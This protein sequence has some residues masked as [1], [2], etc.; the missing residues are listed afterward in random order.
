MR[1]ASEEAVAGRAGGPTER[2][3]ED[4][5]GHGGTQRP[6]AR[7]GEHRSPAIPYVDI[8]GQ[9]RG[10]KAELLAA[11]GDVLDEAQ[12]VLG[13][14]VR[15]FEARFAELCGVRH[16]VAVNSGTD[17]LILSL[18]AL[19]IGPG[20]EVITPPNSFISSASCIVL[21]GARPVF[22]DV[23]DDFNLDPA[24]V[25][26]AITPRTKAILPVHLNGRP[27]QMG[28]IMDLAAAHGLAVV[29]DA[30]EAVLARYR[31]QPVGSFGIG[32]FSL[33]PLKTLNACGDGGVLTTDDERLAEQFR[34]LRNLGLRNRDACVLWSSNS[35]LDTIQAAILLVKLKYLEAWTL[36]R[37]EHAACYREALAGVPGVRAP[38]DRPEEWAVYHRFVIQAERRD[39]LKQFLAERGVETAVH[40]PIP[41][42]LQPAARDLGY[43]PG[44]FPMTERQAA[45]IL[46]LPVYPELSPQ[47]REEVVRAIRA[48]Y[49]PD[50][51]NGSLS[52]R[53]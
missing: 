5:L 6:A 38:D 11:I 23:L 15:E 39:A 27:A 33:H 44:S 1:D 50:A 13:D 14:R 16:A 21:V 48:F 22:V 52:Q 46:S 28:P 2:G 18:R 40:Y 8:A 20:D 31:G 26:A 51:A 34:Q 24:Q 32:C 53:R 41:I 29:E 7:V 35:R 37:R 30:A 42:H 3:G 43:G 45:R 10:L 4:G 49:A 9:H 19:E 12:F 25:E 17:A 36:A 47:E